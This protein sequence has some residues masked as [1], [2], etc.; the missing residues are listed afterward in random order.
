MSKSKNIINYYMLVNKLKYK[1]RNGWIEIGIEEERLESVAEHIYGC[2]MLAVAIDSEYQLKLDINKVL[3]M[4]LL[5]ELEE[6]LMK[7]FTIRDNITKEEKD[8]I[9]IRKV[10]EVT[11]GLLKQGEIVS[12]VQQFNDRKTK[13]AIFA[14]HID[15]IECDMQAKIYDLKGSFKLEK[16]KEDLAF[17]GERAKEIEKSSKTASDYWI[18]YDVPKF[19]DDEIFKDLI[20]KIKEYK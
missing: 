14:Y 5:H 11:N 18:E 13:E 1:I 2:M 12:L 20:E 6:V 19:I 17:Y 16:A 7:D 3:K 15:K 4:L 10:I 8:E 9:G